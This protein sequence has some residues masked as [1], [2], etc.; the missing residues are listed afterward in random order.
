MAD[1]VELPAPGA[2]GGPGRATLWLIAGLL[3]AAAGCYPDP[4]DLRGGNHGSG[5]GGT[6]AGIGGRT[7]TSDAGVGGRT[8]TGGGGVGGRGGTGG[9]GVG[10]SVGSGGATAGRCGAPPCG[11]N[12]IG[13]WNVIQSCLSPIMDNPDCPGESFS[14]AGLQRAG[15]ITFTTDLKYSST[16]TNS[17]TFVHETPTTCLDLD[18]VTCAD[19]Q[20]AYLVET[21]P[22][23]ATLLSASCTSTGISCRCVLGLIPESSS[24]SGLYATSGTKVTTTSTAAGG[25]AETD[26]YCVTGTTMR[27]ISPDSTPTAPQETVFQKQ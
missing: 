23:A 26:D 7:G 11:G 21:Q 12:L 16:V 14:F 19:L 27:L 4:D 2:V 24:D 8:G 13:T 22:P 3:S 1:G 5:T 17:G 6:P 20:A 18:G 15:F 9:A 10:G 25:T